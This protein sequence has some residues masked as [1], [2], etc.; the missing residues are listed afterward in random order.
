MASTAPTTLQATVDR[1]RSRFQGAIIQPGDAEYDA[2]RRVYN[3]MIDRSPALILRA[4]SPEDVV[5]GVHAAREQ[6]LA[7]SIRSGSHNVA[8]FGTND[9]GIVLDL[10]GMNGVLIDPARKVATVDG[11]ATWAVLD[12]AAWEHGLATPGGVISTTGVAGLGLGGGFGHL[13]RRFGLVIDNLLSA[14]LVT[15]DGRQVRASADENADLFWAIRGGGGNFGV[16]TRM[17]LRLHELPNLYGGP[18]FY[19]ASQSEQ[20]LRFYRDFI[21]DA[22]REMSAFFGY[23][24][25]PPAPFVPEPL[26]GHKACAIVVAYTGPAE[27]AEEAVR[28]LREAGTVALD[29]A[30]PIPYPALNSLFDDLLPHGLHHYWKADF[31]KELTDDA[32]EIHAECGPEVPNFHSL[33][34]LYPLDGA[35]QDIASDATAFAHRDVKFTHIIAGIDS[36]GERMPEHRDWVRRYWSALHP[37]SDGGAYVNFL[38][39]EGQDRIR[40]TYRDN[41][42]RL[43]RVKAAW[44]PGNLFNQNQNI[45]PAG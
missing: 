1:L 18:L 40:A 29:L 41:Y 45:E 36:D 39:N 4:A 42:P 20:V 43:A 8:G 23:H 15:A 26:Q 16:V 33:M 22:P 35:V 28:P 30:G 24:V 14:D 31:V 10:S 32:I 3:A 44:D 7:L 25:A 9:G 34:H 11:G 21:A 2:A 5:L 17:Q 12:A 38:M 13:T 27:Q 37:H 6:G 19:P